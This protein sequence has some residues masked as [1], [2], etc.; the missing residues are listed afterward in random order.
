MSS[1]PWMA[2]RATRS[3][4]TSS[5]TVIWPHGE[6]PFRQGVLS[7][8]PNSVG[9]SPAFLTTVTAI[10]AKGPATAARGSVLRVTKARAGKQLSLERQ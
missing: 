9:S 8:S 1:S 3:G 10:G 5:D 6:P 4:S 7:G 2:R